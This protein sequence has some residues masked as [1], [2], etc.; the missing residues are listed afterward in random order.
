MDSL[1]TQSALA[2]ESLINCALTLLSWPAQYPSA[3]APA[4]RLVEKTA[5]AVTGATQRGAVCEKNHSHWQKRV[6]LYTL[7]IVVVTAETRRLS[8]T[9]IYACQ[10]AIAPTGGDTRRLKGMEKFAFPPKLKVCL[11]Y[12]SR[13]FCF[14]LPSSSL[15]SKGYALSFCRIS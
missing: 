9:G 2:L 8:K 15:Y 5:A 3:L 10:E 13:Q 7:G 4:V 1:L 12:K 11:S 14:V 6:E